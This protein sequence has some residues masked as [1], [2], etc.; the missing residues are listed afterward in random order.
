MPEYLSD[1][2]KKLL[3]GL[4]TIDPVKRLGYEKDSEEIKNMAY[5]KEIDFEIL[6]AK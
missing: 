4:L 1:S 2:A 5:F 3:R 6:R